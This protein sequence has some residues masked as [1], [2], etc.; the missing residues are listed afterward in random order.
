MPEVPEYLN[1]LRTAQTIA[2]AIEVAPSL[3]APMHP[4]TGAYTVDDQALF[5]IRNEINGKNYLVSVKLL[6]E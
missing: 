1:T 5:R 3:L 6:P 4:I 2:S